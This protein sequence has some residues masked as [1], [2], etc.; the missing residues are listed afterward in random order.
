MPGGVPGGAQHTPETA[1]STP[2]PTEVA[3]LAAGLLA[4]AATSDDPAILIEAAK[5]LL[6]TVG[7][8]DDAVDPEDH[9]AEAAAG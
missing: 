2:S 4:Q 5:A 8:P 6:A 9:D 7:R 3:R 1:D